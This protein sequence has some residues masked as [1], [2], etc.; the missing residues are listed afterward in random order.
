MRVHNVHVVCGWLRKLGVATSFSVGKSTSS[1]QAEKE[2]TKNAEWPSMLAWLEPKIV[3]FFCRKWLLAAL[4]CHHRCRLLNRTQG[5]PVDQVVSAQKNLHNVCRA[6]ATYSIRLRC[7]HQITAITI[8]G[9]QKAFDISSAAWPDQFH[10]LR[11]K[12]SKEIDIKLFMKWASSLILPQLLQHRTS[13]IVRNCKCIW[14]ETIC[15][16]LNSLFIGHHKLM[17]YSNPR[18][19]ELIDF[20]VIRGRIIAL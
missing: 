13:Q 15:C 3:I 6:K 8:L 2:S 16:A 14:I 18:T 7:V 11:I 19:L 12:H 5:K 10:T 1:T 4:F 20:A 17:F 9:L